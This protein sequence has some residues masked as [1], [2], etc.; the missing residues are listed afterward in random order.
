LKEYLSRI[1]AE[2]GLLPRDGQENSDVHTE[3]RARKLVMEDVR[4]I[5]HRLEDHE[6]AIVALQAKQD[7]GVKQG[8]I[9]SRALERRMDEGFAVATVSV[10][11]LREMVERVERY[12]RESDAYSKEKLSKV[13][14]EVLERL[15]VS[16]F[17]LSCTV[18]KWTAGQI[19]GVADSKR[20]ATAKDECCG[21]G[22]GGR[23]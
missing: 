8:S 15:E 23:R 19:F 5:L 7:E 21:E 1:A 12:A 9:E 20:R 2:L 11:H 16:R 22:D 18:S 3:A 4:S 13:R 10:E 6:D 14:S 17:K